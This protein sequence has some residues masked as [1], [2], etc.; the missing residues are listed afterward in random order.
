MRLWICLRHLHFSSAGVCNDMETNMR[1]R[2]ARVLC[3][4]DVRRITRLEC[5]RFSNALRDWTNEHW[6]EYV[7]DSDAV[8]DAME[9]PTAVM[10]EAGTSTMDSDGA[11]DCEVRV[12]DIY[13]AM[14]KE[15]RKP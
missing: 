10:D 6:R 12:A 15:A 14:I 1:E 4:Q 3:V 7:V 8:L 9:T 11:H 5:D 13:A 2:I